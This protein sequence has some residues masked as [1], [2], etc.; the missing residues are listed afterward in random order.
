MLEGEQVCFHDDFYTVEGIWLSR[1]K[2]NAAMLSWTPQALDELELAEYIRV[3]C[4]ASEAAANLYAQKSA[5][6][7][8]I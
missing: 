5:C 2:R 4:N 7:V 3:D 1:F 6:V 8:H